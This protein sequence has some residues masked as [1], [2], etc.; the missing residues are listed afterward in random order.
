MDAIHK[1]V[2]V[3]SYQAPLGTYSSWCC[4]CLWSRSH[5]PHS[6]SN[7][8]KTLHICR[9]KHKH[10]RTRLMC[11]KPDFPYLQHS[12]HRT[13]PPS[14]RLSAS[15]HGSA[16]GLVSFSLAPSFSPSLPL[17]SCGVPSVQKYA[18]VCSRS[19]PKNQSITICTIGR[20]ACRGFQLAS[21]K[22]SLVSLL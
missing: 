14:H 18:A 2:L 15:S 12:M 9:H 13:M 3:D 11:L 8:P 17:H 5:T 16:C 21:T 4:A 22:R 7:Q 20:L 10:G 19:T 6:P 1:T